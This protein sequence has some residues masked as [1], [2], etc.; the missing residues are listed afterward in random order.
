MKSDTDFHTFVST[1]RRRILL[2]DRFEK[3][4]RPLSLSLSLPSIKAS[5]RPLEKVSLVDETCVFSA[6]GCATPPSSLQ[7]PL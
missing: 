7:L 3:S 2:P 5:N 4:I 1:S 6:T